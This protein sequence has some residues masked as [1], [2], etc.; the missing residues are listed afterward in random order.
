M[1]TRRSVIPRC[2]WLASKYAKLES[3]YA[4]LVYH[5][6]KIYDTLIKE[7]SL[8]PHSRFELFHTKA[9]KYN[10]LEVNP[11]QSALK[12]NDDWYQTTVHWLEATS[13]SSTTFVVVTSNETFPFVHITIR[14]PVF[15]FPQEVLITG[16]LTSAG[17]HFRQPCSILLGRSALF[18]VSSKCL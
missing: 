2:I 6:S 18:K 13:L 14:L 7:I 17:E 12:G 4:F 16:P 1:S 3:F 5:T 15:G 10:R 9:S 11:K 8:R